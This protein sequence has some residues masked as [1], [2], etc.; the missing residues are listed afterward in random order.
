MVRRKLELEDQVESLQAKL[1]E[2][3]Q[4]Q[5]CMDKYARA[6]INMSTVVPGGTYL[7]Y[8]T[9]EGDGVPQWALGIIKELVVVYSDHDVGLTKYRIEWREI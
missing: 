6:I 7:T 4:L 5:M 2:K 9:V 1:E 8:K 3:G